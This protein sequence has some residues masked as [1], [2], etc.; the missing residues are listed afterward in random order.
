MNVAFI[1]VLGFV[2]FS[3]STEAHLRGVG[4]LG[5]WAPQLHTGLLVS[6]ATQERVLSAAIVVLPGCHGLRRR[7]P[8]VFGYRSVTQCDAAAAP[9]WTYNPVS[10][11]PAGLTRIR[12]RLPPAE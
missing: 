2:Q 7:F 11:R 9:D 10:A 4:S 1:L 3:R 8:D 6:G 12:F 5:E